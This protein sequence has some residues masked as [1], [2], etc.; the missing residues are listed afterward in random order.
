M[1]KLSVSAIISSVNKRLPNC[2]RDVTKLHVTGAMRLGANALLTGSS[3]CK[4]LPPAACC[5]RI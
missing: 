1:P 3:G 2:F 4:A 5:E